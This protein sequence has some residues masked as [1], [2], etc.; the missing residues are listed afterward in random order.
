MRKKKEIK[1]TSILFG[2]IEVATVDDEF[3][4]IGFFNKF[5]YH[6]DIGWDW[7]DEKEEKEL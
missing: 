6:V 5:M 1:Y 3:I 7:I 4:A 2:A